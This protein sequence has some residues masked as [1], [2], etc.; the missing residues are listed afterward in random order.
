MNPIKPS[1]LVVDQLV[2]LGFKHAQVT[3][4][5]D[6]ETHNRTRPLAGGGGTYDRIMANLEDY[7]GRILTDILCVVT[8]D[9][10]P[11]AYQLIDTLSE[12]G[13]AQRRVRVQFSP[14]S[15]NTRTETLLQIKGHYDKEGARLREAEKRLLI[16]IAKLSIYGHSRGLV[17][18]LLPQ[19]TWCAMQR[20]DER[21]LVLEPD[22]TL[23]TCAMLVG[24]SGF[25]AGTISTGVGGIDTMMKENYRRAPEC[26]QCKYLPICSD[27]RVDNLQK[28][29]DILA[30]KSHEEVYDLTV[31][32]L[33]EGY[34]RS[35]TLPEPEIA[36]V[37]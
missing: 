32:L 6:R 24:R 11:A 2:P 31:P 12:K 7:A 19:R 27:C 35:L 29:G 1:Q 33:V 16:E 34:Y 5:G 25:E 8:E 28:Q 26:L 23:R 18:S 9:R 37:A 15:P 30:T 14:E 3:I 4:D 10:V 17:E 36:G 20:H 21:H 22:G 13:L